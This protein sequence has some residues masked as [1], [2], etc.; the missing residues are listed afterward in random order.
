MPVDDSRYQTSADEI[1]PF[2]GVGLSARETK[3]RFAGHGDGVK[4]SAA[5]AAKSGVPHFLG[6]TTVKHLVD[7]LIVV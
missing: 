4:K 6:I 3:S 5:Q 1:D 7:D 2:V